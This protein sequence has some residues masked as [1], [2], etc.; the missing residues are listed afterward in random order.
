MLGAIS[1]PQ[2][3]S[4]AVSEPLFWQSLMLLLLPHA[5]IVYVVNRDA[6]EHDRTELWPLTVCLFSLP[7]V[8]LYGHLRMQERY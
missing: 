1:S 6:K 2:I 8:F 7:A 5:F 3:L 4:I